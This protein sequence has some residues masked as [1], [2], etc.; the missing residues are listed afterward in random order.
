MDIWTDFW[1]GLVCSEKA[2]VCFGCGA[3]GMAAWWL[4]VLILGKIIKEIQY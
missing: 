4:Y 2:L 3:D 1:A